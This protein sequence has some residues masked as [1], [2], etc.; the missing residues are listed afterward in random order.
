MASSTRRASTRPSTARSVRTNASTSAGTA[1]SGPRSTELRGEGRRNTVEEIE[2]GSCSPHRAADRHRPA[3]ALVQTPHGNVMWDCITLVDD[4]SVAA[5]DSTRRPG[6]DRDLAPAFLREHG[7]PGAP[8]STIARSISTPPT[9]SGSSTARRACGC[10]IGETHEDRCRGVT[11][12]NTGGHFE[13]AI[14]LHWA[15]GPRAA[16]CCWW[17]TR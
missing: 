6:G 16:A 4:A 11:L 10:G 15:D 3:R 9:P 1:S 5:L 7:R 2:P 8:R 12:I 13:G 14:A 17:A